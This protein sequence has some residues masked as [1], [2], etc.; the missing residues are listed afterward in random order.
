MKELH[1]E[2][3]DRFVRSG[4]KELLFPGVGVHDLP[5]IVFINL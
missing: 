1:E 4:M 2:T 5:R 3:I